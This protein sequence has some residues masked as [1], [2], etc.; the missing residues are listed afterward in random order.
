[1]IQ[2][3]IEVVPKKLFR[4][5][6][7]TPQDVKLLKDKFNI[8]KIISLD[9]QAAKSIHRACKLLGIKQVVLHRG[10]PYRCKWYILLTII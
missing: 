2:R 1:M 10:L 4:G 9:E 7:P 8:N 3:F 5:S 6:A